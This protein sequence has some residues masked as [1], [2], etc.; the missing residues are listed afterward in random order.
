MQEKHMKDLD[1]YAAYYLEKLKGADSD[2]AYKSLIEADHAIVPLLIKA[3]RTESIPTIRATL[4]KIIWQ[5]RIPETIHS[6]L[7]LSMT[8]I[9]KFGRMLWTGLWLLVT[10][11]QFRSWNRQ[12]SIFK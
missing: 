7:R 10:L 3:Y 11:H 5:H 6:C 8:I 1:S 2:A 12:S 4:V 9:Q